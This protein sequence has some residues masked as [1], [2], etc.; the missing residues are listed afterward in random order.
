M[1]EY[2]FV[3]SLLPELEIGHV[4]D[5]GMS[6]LKELLKVNLASE[7]LTKTRLL[8]RQIDVENFRAFW[9]QEPLDPRGNLNKEEIEQAINDKAWSRDEEFPDYLV[10]FLDKFTEDDERLAHF[11]K[12]LISYY[13]YEREHN[14][15]FL[16]DYFAFQRDWQWVLV[17]FRARKMG[18]DIAVELQHEDPSD[19]LIAQILAQKDAAEYEP[20]FEYRDLKPIFEEHQDQPLELHKALYAYQFKEIVERWGVAIFTVDRILNY[21]ARL[22]LVEKWQELDVQKGIEVIDQIEEG[23]K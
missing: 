20:P 5:L 18:K 10:D 4:P 8:L 7:D 19:P 9:A 12:L 17:G 14:E 2:Y 6:E 3:A 1:K 11:P 16:K 13:S 23:V 15:G 21:M 22:I